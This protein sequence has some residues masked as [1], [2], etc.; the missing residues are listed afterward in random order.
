MS[1]GETK[2]PSSGG[3]RQQKYEEQHGLAVHLNQLLNC[4]MFCCKNC[5][6]LRKKFTMYYYHMY[7]QSL[8]SF[9]GKI[10]TRN[11]LTQIITQQPT[12]SENVSA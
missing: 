7:F 2:Q 8:M 10:T 1:S 9:G 4:L 3:D 5:M 6:F 11:I 12:F